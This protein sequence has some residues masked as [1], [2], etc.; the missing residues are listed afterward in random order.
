MVRKEKAG[1][2]M[3]WCLM[4]FENELRSDCYVNL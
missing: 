4:G 1:N 3:F 2:M